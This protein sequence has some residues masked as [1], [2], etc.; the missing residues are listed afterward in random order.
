MLGEAP[1]Y[2]GLEM[3]VGQAIRFDGMR[4]YG[5]IVPDHG[6]E[7]VLRHVN[8]VRIPDSHSWPGMVV[9]F[10]VEGVEPA[11]KASGVRHAQAAELPVP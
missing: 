6:G 10:E 1:E 2:R 11:L 3:V 7:D 5:F 4:E 8:N 9:A